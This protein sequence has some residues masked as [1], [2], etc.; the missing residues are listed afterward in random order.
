MAQPEEGVCYAHKI[1]KAEA[2]VDWRL[3]A[4]TLARRVRALHPF[5][6]AS[7]HLGEVAIKLWAAHVMNP[8]PAAP[9]AAAA[10]GTVLVADAN[11]VQVQCGEGVLCVT[12]L[13]RAGGKRLSA[14]AFLRGF[15]LTPGQ[16]FD[17]V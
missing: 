11:G 4:T 13:Q 6:A 9:L 7:A 1:D 14:D 10:P 5:P 15:P 16:C 8:P 17:G 3:P 12:E 2:A